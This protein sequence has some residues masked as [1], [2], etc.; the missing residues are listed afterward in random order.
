MRVLV[1][2]ASGHIG[3]AVV[4]ELLAAG[5][6]VVGLARSDASAAAVA[7][8]GA[9]VTRG[10]LDDLDGLKQAAADADGVVHLAFKPLAGGDFLSAVSAD[11]AA[12]NAFGEALAGTGKP[13]VGTTGTMLCALGGVTGRP[14]TELDAFPGGPRIDAEN[15]V[16]AMAQRNVRSSIVRLAPL[17]HSTLDRHG[18]TLGLI[19]I[20]R[21]TGVSAY[22]GDG[23]NRWPAV[24][25]LDAARLYRLALEHAPAGSR[26]HAAGDDGIPFREIAEAIGR[27][28]DVPV[29]SL[30]PEEAAG[31]FTYL[32]PFVGLDNCVSTALTRQALGWEPT[33]PNWVEDLDNY[34]S[35]QG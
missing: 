4:P 11:L 34:F 35:R 29:K 15:A 17:V 21:A 28:L 2:G 22:V 1:T 13:F 20:A 32:A 7:E 5:H 16:I 24:H 10:D 6:E 26:T 23:S 33:H 31:H 3:S 9:E 14:G 27:R 30:D 12:V 18:F 19:G 25:T 8:L